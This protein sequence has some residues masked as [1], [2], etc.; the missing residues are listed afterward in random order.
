MQDTPARAP[1]LGLWGA[2]HEERLDVALAARVTRDQLGRRLPGWSISLFAPRDHLPRLDP[3]GRPVALGVWTPD[4]LAELAAELDGVIVGPGQLVTVSG[5]GWLDPGDDAGRFFIEGL[6]DAGRAV[7]MVWQGISVPRDLAP[8]EEARVRKAMA[9]RAAISVT[10]DASGRR[11]EALG[12]SVDVELIPHPAILAGETFPAEVLER[13]LRYLRTMGWY[14][15]DRP[16]LVVRPASG[17][18]PAATAGAVARVAEGHG[19]TPVVLAGGDQE[20][21]AAEALAGELGPGTLLLGPEATVEDAVAA[22]AHAGG[23]MGASV[24]CAAVALAHDRPHVLLGERGQAQEGFARMIGRPEAVV[25]D[26]PAIPE[27]FAA[28]VSWSG[29]GAA[30]ERLRLRAAD[31]FD[32]L[33]R[34]LRRA[35]PDARPEPEERIAALEEELSALRAA[36]AVRSRRLVLDA[37][38]FADD[39]QAQRLPM[40][41]AEELLRS[42]AF[43]YTRWLRSLVLSMSRLGR[44]R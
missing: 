36:Y 7:P 12:A 42:R 5:A 19:M 18:D 11:L 30:A 4:R 8:D 35:V 24:A 29:R 21:G 2:L 26:P 37:T 16:A 6:A 38:A 15:E 14:P 41:R 31:H 1:R 9:S 34:L 25:V 20:A 22:V 27:A 10:D 39:L 13:R 28:A 17:W 3:G 23:L 32:D 44:R 43:R 40:R 33:A